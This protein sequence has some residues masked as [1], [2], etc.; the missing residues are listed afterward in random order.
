MKNLLL[1]LKFLAAVKAEEV[2]SPAMTGEWEFTA[3]PDGARQLLAREGFMSESRSTRRRGIIKRVKA[4]EEDDSAARVT[5]IISPTDGKPMIETLRGYKSKDGE[6]MIYK[7]IGNRKMAESRRSE[8][9]SLGT[10]RSAPWTTSARRP[11]SPSARCFATTR[12]R[13]RPSLYSTASGI[14]PAPSRS[15]SPACTRSPR[16][17]PRAS[18]R[19][20]TST[21][22]RRAT[23]SGRSRTA[24]TRS[25]PAAPG[26]SFPAT[27]RA[28]SSW[29]CSRRARPT[30][31]TSSGA[32]AQRRP[33]N[34]FLALK[35]D[36]STG[37][38]FDTRAHPRTPMPPPG[39]RSWGGRRPRSKTGG[40]PR[41]QGR[42]F[43][44]RRV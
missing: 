5:D 18:G 38:E 22:P 14:R 35:E 36:G 29:R 44:A 39:G 7:V 41:P 2:T 24:R 34:A 8:G 20:P 11:A 37:F 43:A 28:T 40:R 9:S 3:A 6:L 26:G 15:T 1:K 25:W 10:A 32:C 13:K 30:C 21:R 23:S 19:A 17:P 42:P 33:F 4:F 31:S 12:R 16:P 27:S